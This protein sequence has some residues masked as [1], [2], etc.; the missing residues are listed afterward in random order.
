MIFSPSPLVS[1]RCQRPLTLPQTLPADSACCLCPLSL[2]LR[3][4]SASALL[5]QPLPCCL[6]PCSLLQ[7]AA[8]ARCRCSL[9]LPLSSYSLWLPTLS[10]PLLLTLPCLMPP[11]TCGCFR[12]RQQV[13]A[14]AAARISIQL[15]LHACVCVCAALSLC[16]SLSQCV[17]VC[18]SGAL[19][20]VK[21]RVGFP[22]HT[23]HR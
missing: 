22:P 9:P 11:T 19:K 16:V 10:P 14:V 12:R 15:S 4:A 2:P 6:S 23:Q 17:C 5:P 21:I 1:P 7:H 3:V 13:E 18:V 8:F 20:Y